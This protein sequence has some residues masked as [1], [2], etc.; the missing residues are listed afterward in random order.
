MCTDI[1]CPV[2]YDV[3][4]SGNKKSQ[5]SSSD[6]RRFRWELYWSFFSFCSCSAVAAGDTHVGAGTNVS[7]FE[8]RDANQSEHA[9]SCTR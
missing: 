5:L 7:L 4:C 9:S 1:D 3:T 6:L 2:F 8:M